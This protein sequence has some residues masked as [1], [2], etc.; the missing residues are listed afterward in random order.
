VGAQQP[1]TGLCLIINKSY[2]VVVIE[3]QALLDCFPP[4]TS[5]DSSYLTNSSV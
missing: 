1:F 4:N 5:R 2:A 3:M